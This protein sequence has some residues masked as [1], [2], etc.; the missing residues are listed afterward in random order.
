MSYDMEEERLLPNATLRWEQVRSQK[1]RSL[2]TYERSSFKPWRVPNMQ[3][4]LLNDSIGMVEQAWN[5]TRDSSWG[6]VFLRTCPEHARHGV[7]ESIKCETL[8][9]TWEN[10]TRL[11]NVMKKEDPNGCII[12]MPFIKAACSSVAY[13]STRDV[14]DGRNFTGYMSI[15]PGHDGVTAGHGLKIG[16]P[17][18]YGALENRRIHDEHNANPLNHQLEFVFDSENANRALFTQYRKGPQATPVTPPPCPWAKIGII[19]IGEVIVKEVWEPTG[20]E[21]VAWLEENITKDKLPEGFVVVEQAGDRNSHIYAHC[22]FNDIPY[23]AELSGDEINIGDRWVGIDSWV[24]LDNEGEFE[25]QPYNP[26]DYLETFKRGVEHSNKY[27]HV[28]QGWLSTFFHQFSGGQMFS[29]T[30]NTAFLA[31]V[32]AGYLPKAML[33]VG[34]GEMRHMFNLHTSCL[35]TTPI[36]IGLA[37]QEL[38]R[39]CDNSHGYDPSSIRRDYYYNM[40]KTLLDYK[41]AEEMSRFLAQEFHRPGWNSGFGGKKWGQSMDICTGLY[42]AL[43]KFMSNPSDKTFKALC[44][45]VNAGENAEHNNGN[46]LNKFL[47]SEAFDIGT[48][49]LNV[50]SSSHMQYATRIFNTADRAVAIDKLN[51]DVINANEIESHIESFVSTNISFP[52]TPAK[53]PKNTWSFVRTTRLKYTPGWL[54][55]NGIAGTQKLM[56]EFRFRKTDYFLHPSHNDN[57]S[58][59][60]DPYSIKFIECTHDNCKL[61]KQH[62][63]QKKVKTYT[64]L[65]DSLKTYYHSI[66]A[67]NKTS[68]QELYDVMIAGEL[69]HAIKEF[70]VKV[71][72]KE[73][74]QLN[75]LQS[76]MDKELLTLAWEFMQD[77]HITKVSSN[78]LNYLVKGPYGFSEEYKSFSNIQTDLIEMFEKYHVEIRAIMEA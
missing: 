37:F 15:G 56:R 22:N 72:Q 9:D 29:S 46:L 48:G 8:D 55:K 14:N 62:A 77:E 50:H 52:I 51:K 2:R 54:I 64:P 7:L 10:Y 23:I 33:A 45:S 47:R 16:V 67:V 66:H 13:L 31:G 58:I 32:F 57:E 20:L 63:A 41:H 30:E 1:A 21:E 24:V 49:G 25:P 40:T 53:P 27:W 61:C 68:K 65:L 26:C 76:I 6:P 34:L 11:A 12:M 43:G 78:Y 28:D 19:T 71:E 3:L 70:G 42:K 35:P 4:L 69:K 74:A 60:A 36:V 38:W 39:E 5:D 17:L 18:Q 59:Y 73:D 75:A 44:S